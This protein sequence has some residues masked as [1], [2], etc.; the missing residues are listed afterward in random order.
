MQT[1]PPEDFCGIQN[2]TTQNGE[3]LS[4]TVF[5]SVGG[6]YVVAGSAVFR[7]KTEDFNGRPVYHITGS[8][9]SNST[10]DFIYKVRDRYESYIDTATMQPLKFVRDVQ[11]GNHK[12]YENI[13]F[14]RSANTAIT[15]SGV[16]KVPACIQDVLS[17]IYYARNID[18]S[19]YRK[20]DKIPFRMF[21]ENEVND[22]YIRYLGKE[23]VK[24]KYGRFKA[25]KFSTLLI[26]GTVFKGGENMTVWVSDDAN[27]IPLRIES[28]ILI[29][30]IKVDMTGYKNLRHAL[31]SLEKKKG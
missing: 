2:T 9:Q 6:I 18:F 12:K 19:K 16:F 8:G 20:N 22:L 15:D 7:N 14:N 11:D 26:A 23:A 30:S 4:Y 25:I 3:E 21:L 17:T 29:G 5:Y 28:Q 31:S 13:S 27:H 24:T 1:S 10:Y